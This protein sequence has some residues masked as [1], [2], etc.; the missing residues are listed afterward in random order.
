MRIG[1]SL[2]SSAETP[3]A[4]LVLLD[5]S[6]G[7]HDSDMRALDHWVDSEQ[8]M[9]WATIGLLESG[10]GQVIDRRQKIGHLSI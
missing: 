3:A 2:Q 1:T 10:C 5:V 7:H 8:L 4:L 6:V 9:A